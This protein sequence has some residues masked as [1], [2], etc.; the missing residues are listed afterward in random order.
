MIFLYSPVLSGDSLVSL[1]LADEIAVD[2]L[3]FQ[4]LPTIISTHHGI[5]LALSGGGARGIAHIGAI[6]ALEEAGIPI[7]GIAGT[8]IGAVIGGFYAAGYTLSEITEIVKNV[9]W[10]DIFLDAPTRKSLPLSRKSSQSSAILELRFD[11]VRP[12][13]PPALSAG[14]NISNLLLEKINQAPYRGEPNFDHLK[15]PFIAVCTDLSNG[16]RI[17]FEDGDLT[18]AILAS[19]SFPLLIAPVQVQ[20]RLLIDGG[21]A[22]N[23][24]VR[25]ARKFGDYVVAVD[26]SMPPILG[27]PPFQPWVIANQ[28]T[29]LM[30][31]EE[32]EKL[33][34]EA[35]LVVK[36]LSDSLDTFTMP[37]IYQAVELGYRAMQTVIPTIQAHLDSLAGISDSSEVK[38]TYVG[39]KNNT[40]PISLEE[41]SQAYRTVR[42]GFY[43]KRAEIAHDLIHLEKDPRVKSAQ[44]EIQG[45]SITYIIKEDP[46]VTSIEFPGVK[47][48]STSDLQV[49][50]RP[51]RRDSSKIRFSELQFERILRAYRR[52]G[53]PLAK[54]DT[55]LFEDNGKI[56]ISI[57]EGMVHQVCTE[58]TESISPKRILRDFQFR[59]GYPLNLFDLTTGIQELYGSDLFSLIRA[60]IE[61]GII[62]IKVQERPTPRLRLGAGADSERNGRGLV[63]LSQEA[64]PFIG[65]SFTGKVHYGEFDEL[66]E[67]SYKNLAIFST[68]L[69]GFCS[70][71]S[72]RTEYHYFNNEGESQ[73][74]YHF[75]RTGAS[76]YIGL[77]FRTWGR[78]S[79]GL[80]GERV[81]SD[82]GKSPDEFDLNRIFLRSEYDTQDQSEFP[83]SGMKYNFLLESA[84]AALGGDIFFQQAHLQ[85]EDA[86]PITHRLTLLGCLQ[87]GI[88]DQATPFS[89]WFRLGGEKSFT[90]LH[91]AE[92]PG[93]Q[94]LSLT[95]ELREDLISRFLAD[96]YITI[97]GDIG[98]VWEDIETDVTSGDTRKSVGMSFA[99]D[100]FLGPMSVSYG[101]LFPEDNLKSR[102]IVYFNIGHRF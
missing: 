25:A 100:T 52:A 27:K 59:E 89:E 80:R 18:E 87:G 36:P 24:P 44:A 8:S 32:N 22:E 76:A 90:G 15:I 83:T 84:P 48:F 64:F 12:Y 21:V 47:Q 16:E 39:V 13:I 42:R 29:G 69:E 65:G 26:V 72:S 93:R 37:D 68:Y 9:D 88:C 77:Q 38:I 23:I 95:I 33:A 86:L 79:F 4:S 30:A 17:L 102:D 20:N 53:N 60:T 3:Q 11:G 49:L 1:N 85:I 35:N 57:S 46:I 45:D 51:E 56:I 31:Q 10:S 82:H 98:A 40:L 66:Y 71:I 74:L 41:F 34:S 14:Q 78:I 19:M 96:A 61:D 67:I 63:E 55:V 50:I 99:L 58:G 7:D 54:I 91:Y 73:G 6:Q 5:V 81:Y 92:L 62:T 101:H 28:V 75:A 2:A 94:L 70:L 43:P 97:R